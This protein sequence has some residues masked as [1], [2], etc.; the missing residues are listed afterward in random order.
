M[1][2]KAG[3]KLEAVA[4]FIS[5]RPLGP[6]QRE[7]V[8]GAA[9]VASPLTPHAMLAMLH[10]IEML[11]GRERRGARWRARTLDLDIILWS[12]GCVADAQLTIPHPQFRARDFVLGPAA[13]VA[14]GWRDPVTGLT[15]RQLYARLKNTRF[16]R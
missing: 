8:N 14:P 6:S 1:I 5:S 2:G 16:R 3:C 12:G 10:G 4:P 15:L 7:Y 13:Q 9:L 11:H